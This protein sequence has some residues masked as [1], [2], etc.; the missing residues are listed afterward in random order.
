MNKLFQ[1]IR[2]TVSNGVLAL[3]A[4]VI[5]SS[6]AAEFNRVYKSTDNNYKY[7]YAKELFARGKYSQAEN[8]LIE[9]VTYMK[10]SDNVDYFN[11]IIL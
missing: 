8:I 11:T 9:L 7:E 3:F 2:V 1:D 4:A 5:F 10:G 6:C